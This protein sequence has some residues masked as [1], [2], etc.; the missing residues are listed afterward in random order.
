[1]SPFGVGN[2]KA[3]FATSHV[4]TKY[5]QVLKKQ[6]LK[7]YVHQ[8]GCTRVLEA[9]GFGLA[10]HEPLVRASEPYRMFYTI[11]E[12]HYLGAGRLQLNIKELQAM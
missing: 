9:I 6:H 11:E 8:E 5:Y 4:L 12:N 1:M 3:V 2:T 10:Y 7:L